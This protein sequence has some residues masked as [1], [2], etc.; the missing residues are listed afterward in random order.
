MG[1]EKKEFVD[2]G[3][4]IEKEEKQREFEQWQRKKQR[5]FYGQGRQG[6]GGAA[7]APPAPPAAPSGGG[8]EPGTLRELPNSRRGSAHNPT[9]FT[10]GCG[11]RLQFQ[12]TKRPTG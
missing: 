9:T 3:D 11:R 12:F 8:V 4:E 6:A 5:R 1:D 10:W 7:P 2:L